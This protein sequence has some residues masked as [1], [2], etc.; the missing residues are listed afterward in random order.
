M[1]VCVSPKYLPTINPTIPGLSFWVP[2]FGTKN[3]CHARDANEL[4]KKLFENAKKDN[5]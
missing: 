3:N 5:K 4:E 2:G 1:T